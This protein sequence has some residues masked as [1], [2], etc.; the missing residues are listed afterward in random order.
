MKKRLFAFITVLAAMLCLAGCGVNITSISLPESLTVNVG[1]TVDAV[2]T[3]AAD[4]DDVAADKLAEAASKLE[5]TWTSA[6]ESVATVDANGVVTGVAGGETAVTVAA[7]DGLSATVKVNVKVP[8]EGLEVTGTTSDKKGTEEF[9]GTVHLVI[10]VKDSDAL[11]VNAVPENADMASL[12]FESADEDVVTVDAEGK[13]TAVA[14]G[15]ATVAVK[16]G[17]IS[18]EVTVKVDTAPEKIVLEDVT[19]ET[20]HTTKLE[21]TFEGNN[22]TVGKNL[23][24]ASSDEDVVVVDEDG[25]ATAKSAGEATVTATNEFGQ[26]TDV[27]VVVTESVKTT[28]SNKGGA[29]GGRTPAQNN[30]SGSGSGAQAPSN[31]TTPAPSTPDPAPSTPPAPDP[32][33]APTPSTPAEP[34]H[35]HGNGTDTGTCPAC[36]CDYSPDVDPSTVPGYTDGVGGD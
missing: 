19:L 17:E 31:P 1:E 6:D 24:W 3:F 22:I 11:V 8:L 36:G 2:A 30:G 9:D 28:T 33:P 26:K 27:K 25:T 32:T 21:A 20:G 12:E 18:T 29:S 13:L 16:S 14:N 23:T 7:A 10:N 4:K 35:Y 15:E 5:L 34:Q